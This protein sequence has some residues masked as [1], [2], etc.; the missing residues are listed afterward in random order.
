MGNGPGRRG[1]GPSIDV[2][3]NVV[4]FNSSDAHWDI[5]P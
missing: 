1:Q 2:S 3:G 4:P 5:Y